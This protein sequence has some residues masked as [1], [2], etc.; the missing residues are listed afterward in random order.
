VSKIENKKHIN[1]LKGEKMRT[2]GLI[3]G[4]LMT[5]VSALPSCAHNV[6]PAATGT[7]TQIT[8][9]IMTD[10]RLGQVT[11]AG[12]SC[13]DAFERCMQPELACK[14]EMKACTDK[15]ITNY[16]L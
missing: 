13:R 10:A 12:R 6:K 11:Q 7:T 16:N 8:R 15:I 4:T 14:T 2:N 3:L 1:L 9:H 5:I